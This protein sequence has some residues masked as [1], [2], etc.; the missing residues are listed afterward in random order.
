M[1]MRTM[2]NGCIP[3]S[4]SLTTELV[5]S[6]R[7]WFKMGWVYTS[8][9]A[10]KVI[11][12]IM[13]RYRANKLD[14]RKPMGIDALPV[15]VES[16]ISFVI[17]R[18]NPKPARFCLIHPQPKSVQR[19]YPAFTVKW[20][21]MPLY[22][23][24]VHHAHVMPGNW[25]ITSKNRADLRH[26]AIIRYRCPVCYRMANNLVVFTS[27]SALNAHLLKHWVDAAPAKII[28]VA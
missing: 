12:F 4:N 2:R 17:D 10:T 13:L 20:I 11:Q 26:E 16:P 27:T 8:R 7:Y 6:M 9:S 5:S 22:A 21:T 23:C 24:S 3:R 28:A 1:S 19:S 15:G 18:P 14:I 25:L